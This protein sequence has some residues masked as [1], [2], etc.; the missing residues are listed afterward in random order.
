[1]TGPL[2]AVFAADLLNAELETS[3][4]VIYDTPVG[5]R[6][7]YVDPHG[8]EEHYLVHYPQGMTAARHHH[9]A[10]KQSKLLLPRWRAA[11]SGR[12]RRASWKVRPPPSNHSCR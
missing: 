5:L 3:Q 7:L 9:S 6:Q 8:G 2:A 1:M 10:A 12:H 11:L 4:P